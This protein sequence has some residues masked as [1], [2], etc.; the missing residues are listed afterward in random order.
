MTTGTIIPLDG[1]TQW[2]PNA[3]CFLIGTQLETPAGAVAVEDLRIGDLVLTHGG[4]AMPVRWIGRST[5]TVPFGTRNREVAP[6]Q[7]RAGALGENLPNQDLF[8]SPRHCMLVDGALIPAE[9]L[10]NGTSITQ[11]LPSETIEYFHIELDQHECVMVAGV[12]SE[13]FLDNG[14]RFRFHNAHEHDGAVRGSAAP[15]AAPLVEDGPELVQRLLSILD[16]AGLTAKPGPLVGVI[17]VCDTTQIV[18]WAFDAGNPE[19][20]VIV[21]VLLDGELLTATVA[22][23]Y[24]KDVQQAGF[25]LGNAGFAITLVPGQIQDADL[26]RL[27]VR[28]RLDG[29]ALREMAAERLSA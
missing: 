28:R 19:T 1:N 26:P 14:S 21:D 23:D 16:R 25:G 27:E 10:V 12:W 13:S 24:R 11:P 8:V 2:D 9:R 22:S 18:G 3:V 20:P 29:A 17:D 6:I 15:F 5:Y 7:I 4:G